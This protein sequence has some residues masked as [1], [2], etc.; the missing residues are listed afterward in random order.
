MTNITLLVDPLGIKSSRYLGT[1]SVTWYLVLVTSVK[2]IY[3][4]WVV[5]VHHAAPL[6][7]RVGTSLPVRV[8]LRSHPG[9]LASG[10]LSRRLGSRRS[11]VL[12]SASPAEALGM[13]K[14]SASGD[15]C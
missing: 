1:K 14:F 11:A 8:V 7:K 10:S 5:R 2:Y 15:G 13:G 3:N 4:Y 6:P 9:S 12:R